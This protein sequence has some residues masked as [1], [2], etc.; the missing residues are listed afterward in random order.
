MHPTQT[1][2][3]TSLSILA[4]AKI[5]GAHVAPP[6]ARNPRPRALPVRDSTSEAPQ[7]SAI[8]PSESGVP[9][10]PRQGRYETRRPPLHLGQTLRTPRNQFIALLQRK[11]KFQAQ[12]R[13]QHLH[14]F[15]CLLQTSPT[16][17]TPEVTF[18]APPT[19]PEAPPVVPATSTPPPSESSITISSSEFRGLCHT[20]QTLSTTQ[21]TTS[22]GYFAPPEHDMPG[23]SELTTPSE[24]A[25]PVEQTM[26]H[27]KTTIAE[28]ETPIQS[29]QETTAEPSSPH[30]PLTTT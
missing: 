23:P 8:P 9:S 19:T 15:S 12:E 16:V 2:W 25:T 26:P 14:S 18:F 11:P 30:D 24:K 6:S 10:S 28:V 3:N 22:L 4:M 13:H 20:L 21:D 17:P 27:E 29:T 7:A 5:R 1:L